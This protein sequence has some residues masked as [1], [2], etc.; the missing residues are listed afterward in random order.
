MLPRIPAFG[1]N[2]IM[3]AI[4]VLTPD[5]PSAGFW[6][7]FVPA[8]VTPVIGIVVGVVAPESR[9]KGLG[10]GLTSFL[11]TITTGFEVGGLVPPLVSSS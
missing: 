4:W 6:G 9:L 5:D 2:V 3:G 8:V 7:R 10:V 1:A 11:G